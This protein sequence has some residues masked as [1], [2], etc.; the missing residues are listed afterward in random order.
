MQAN[1]LSID[2]KVKGTMEL[3]EVFT[4]Q[5]RPELIQRAVLAEASYRLQPQGHYPLAG[6]QTTATYY[7]AMGTYRSGRHMGIA[8]R[9]RE[10]LGG[11]VQGKVKRIPSAVKGKRA[12]PHII[13]KKLIERINKREYQK[14]IIS[15]ISATA[16]LKRDGI[17]LPIIVSDEIEHVKKT[18]DMMN[19][20]EG[21]KL[22]QFIERSRTP[23]RREGLRGSTRSRIFRRS[24]LLVLGKDAPALKAARNIAGMDVCTV[25]GITASLLAPGGNPGRITIWSEHAVK[26]IAAAVAQ[27][28]LR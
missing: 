26:E 15:A 4:S 14:A 16:S 21:I 17:T 27:R 5:V 24:L 12:H 2:G 11:G 22:S 10:K 3:P 1:I 23:R 25:S 8:I 6:M 13:E 9:P 28:A 19:V 20:I 7:G 18:K